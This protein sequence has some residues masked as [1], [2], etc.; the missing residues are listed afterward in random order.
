VTRIAT[1]SRAAFVAMI[2]ATALWVLLI[3]FF[4]RNVSSESG[5]FLPAPHQV[6]AMVGLIEASTSAE[7]LDMVLAAISSDRIDVRIDPHAAPASGVR[8]EITPYATLLGRPVDIRYSLEDG[9]WISR[10]HWGSR[11]I[12]VITLPISGGRQ[13]EVVVRAPYTVTALGLPLGLGAGMLGT[14]GAL[15]LL[16]ITLRQTGTLI[17]LAKAVDRVDLAGPPAPLPNVRWRAVEIR[18]VAAAFD[19]LQCRLRSILAARLA[20]ISGIA[21]DVRTFA[22]RLRLRVD[23]IADDAE[24]ARA[25]A[26]IEDMIRLLDDALI[27]GRAST[28]TLDL[29]LV[30]FDQFVLN[31]VDDRRA[32]GQPVDMSARVATCQI[33]ADRVALKRILGNVIDNAVHYGRR[34]HVILSVAG[35]SAILSIADDGPGVPEADRETLF[36]PFTRLDPSRSRKTGGSGLGLAVSR[37]LIEAHDG[38]IRFVNV[39]HGAKVEMKF[40]LFQALVG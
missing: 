30:D 22:T 19:R 38:A 13:L 35:A 34:A 28:A 29:E 7:Q 11:N 31:E 14:L 9:T 4:Y 36:E 5:R 33:L 39:A 17:E 2:C 32:L 26:D 15:A 37:T 27:A 25:I 1:I 20:L 18:A 21:H 24:R 8:P 3:G 12:A 16:L 40:P 6:T 10:V 23:D